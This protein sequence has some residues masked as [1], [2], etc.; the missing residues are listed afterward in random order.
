MLSNVVAAAVAIAVVAAI[1]AVAANAL[2]LL[3]LN[4]VGR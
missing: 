3:E 4:N 2:F 1:V